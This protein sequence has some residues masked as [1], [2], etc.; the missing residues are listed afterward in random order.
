M[1]PHPQIALFLIRK[2]DINVFILKKQEFLD[3]FYLRNIRLY[4]IA[5]RDS[6]GK[7]VIQYLSILA[8]SFFKKIEL[9]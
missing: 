4:F 5:T 2:I 8:G 3:Q 1:L 7:P 9:S 6:K